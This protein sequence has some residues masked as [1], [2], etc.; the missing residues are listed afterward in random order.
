MSLM[1]FFRRRKR[2]ASPTSPAPRSLPK[3]VRVELDSVQSHGTHF[4]RLPEWSSY[5]PGPVHWEIPDLVV[6]QAEIEERIQQHA[7]N[8]TLD[9]LV[10]DLLDR[11]IHQR[12]QEIHSRIDLAHEQAIRQLSYLYEQAKWAQTD[13]SERVRELIKRW[14]RSQREYRRAWEELTGEEPVGPSPDTAVIPPALLQVE[15][16][17]PA[18]PVPDPDAPVEERGSAPPENGLVTQIRTLR[19]KYPPATA[20][21]NAPPSSLSTTD[22]DHH[23]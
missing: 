8:G 20:A 12:C 23:V 22:G 17:A 11:E 9:G 5:Q 18:T 13:L 21:T 3:P 14:A 19:G 4:V 15:V 1:D 10:P 2:D 6:Q 7:R 16:S